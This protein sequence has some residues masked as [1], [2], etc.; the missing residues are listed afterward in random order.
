MGKDK[1]LLLYLTPIIFENNPADKKKLLNSLGYIKEK[2]NESNQKIN[3]KKILFI[4]FKK[5]THKKNPP[6]YY[7][8][9]YT[10]YNMKKMSKKVE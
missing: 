3:I 9:D 6:L 1:D 4:Y 7:I 5:F 10:L 2:L 8:C